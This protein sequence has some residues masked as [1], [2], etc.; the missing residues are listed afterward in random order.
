MDDETNNFGHDGSGG[1]AERI[2]Q[3]VK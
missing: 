3:R 2:R 1:R